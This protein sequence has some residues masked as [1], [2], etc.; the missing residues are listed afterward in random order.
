MMTSV[1]NAGIGPAEPEL[2]MIAR[3]AR[4]LGPAYRLF[5]QNPVHVVRGQGVWLYGP[6][7]EAYLD[8]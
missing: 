3:R 6:Q 5:Y 2:E 7:G 8:V 4:L 1:E